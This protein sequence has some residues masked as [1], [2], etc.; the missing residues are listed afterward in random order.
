MLGRTSFRCA[1]RIARPGRAIRPF[2]DKPEGWKPIDDL[3]P[4]RPKS[5]LTRKVEESPQNL[6]RFMKLA[7]VMGYGSP[8]G[9]APVRTFVLYER[10][11][12]TKADEEMAFW[13]DECGLPPTFQSWFTVITLHIW[14]LTVRFRALPAAY[15]KR[16]GEAVVDHF[17]QDVEDR[18]RAI[19]QPSYDYKPYTFASAFYINPNAPTD[20]K[21]Q[22]L[23]RAPERLVGQQLKIFK[24]QWTGFSLAF[25][26][27]LVNGDMEMAAAVW[28]N[29]LG[30]RGASGIAFPDDPSA[31][32]FKRAVNLLGG[33]VVN[34]AKVDFEKE[35]VTDDGSGV[36][37]FPPDQADK[38]LVYPEL[39]LAIVQYTRREL[40]RLEALSDDEIV[41]M[42]WRE[43]RFGRVRQDIDTEVSPPQ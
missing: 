23:S 10:L 5:W 40:V 19:M 12:C 21:K 13:R 22:R 39:M 34:P 36:H 20:D 8:R 4:E 28:R 33:T 24:E 15:G 41:G 16:Y 37:D 9:Q 43:M 7:K 38:Y 25:D 42:D 31:P 29:L 35:A 18:V 30:A 3:I 26:L 11:C 27:G 6:E 32:D 2:S 14:M 17:F 1:G